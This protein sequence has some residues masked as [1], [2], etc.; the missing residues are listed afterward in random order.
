MVEEFQQYIG[1]TSQCSEYPGLILIV[2]LCVLN[3]FVI[4][5]ET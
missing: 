1:N 3:K 4:R 2:P 5:Y